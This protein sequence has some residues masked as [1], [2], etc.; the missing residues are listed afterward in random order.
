MT[1][2]L[3]LTFEMFSDFL[4][5]VKGYASVSVVDVPWMFDVPLAPT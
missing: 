1:S 5:P 2:G 4:E 3:K